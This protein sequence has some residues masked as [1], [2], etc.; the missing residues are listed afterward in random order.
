MKVIIFRLLYSCIDIHI[1]EKKW[2]TLKHS[3]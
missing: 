3:T 2:K 1:G